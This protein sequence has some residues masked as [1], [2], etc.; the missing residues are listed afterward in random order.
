MTGRRRS[1]LALGLLAS[2]IIPFL[3][4]SG[5]ETVNYAYDPRGRLVKV[6]RSGA[7]NN[8][9]SAC[10]AYDDADNRKSVTAATSS[11]CSGVPPVPSFSINSPAAVAEGAGSITFVVSRA[12]S[13]TGSYT[14][15]YQTANGTAVQPGDY[16]AKSGTLTF[17]DGDTSE[18]ISVT[19]ADDSTIE[20]AESFYVDL[21]T[22]SG[23]A[24][25]TT[26]RGTGTINDND[27]P[28]GGVTFAISSNGAVTEGA[29][30]GFTINKSGTTSSSCSV[31][32][33]TANGSAVAPG[34]Y[35]AKSTT[36]LTFT[37]GQGSQPVNVTTIDDSTVESQET[38]T[39]TLS[40][41][42]GG[43]AIGTGTATA[44]IND[45]DSAGTCSGVSFRVAD[46]EDEEGNSLS[47][48]ISKDGSASGN[49]SVNYAT[50][51]NSAVAP[52]D[53]T[54]QSTTTLTFASN[55]L[56]KSISIF[57]GPDSLVEG[58]ETFFVN[59][60]SPT[61]GSTI[62]DAQGLE[63]ILD[64][65]LEQCFDENNQPIPCDFLAAP[66]PVEEVQQSQEEE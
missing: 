64:A 66:P 38:F 65:T 32:Y 10:Y 27:S 33:A 46:A 18:S 58:P 48:T 37:S 8:G 31:N 17:V 13:T 54:P 57:L 6:S 41:P 28:C 45:N 22:A 42:T 47:V 50:A 56:A 39:M 43:A 23:G 61:G 15:T 52:G 29:N 60:S 62:S 34:D 30:S 24:G 36:T 2:C 12:G 59:L 9:A 5:Q 44:Q 35:T 40:S 55:E 49:C 63:T 11:D 21:L 7:I 1:L 4:A 3:P 20:S 53:Y 14:V 51:N 16:T 19:V 25:I 26:S